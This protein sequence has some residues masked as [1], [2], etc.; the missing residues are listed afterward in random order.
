MTRN[1]FLE[2]CIELL[3]DFTEAWFNEFEP[4]EPADM[5]DQDITPM[6]ERFC[7]L[8]LDQ[9]SELGGEVS[10]L[11]KNRQ[12]ITS[13]FE[14]FFISTYSDENTGMA[15]H[16]AAPEYAERL[17]QLAYDMCFHDNER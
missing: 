10:D 2:Y 6:A 3:T 14:D 13:V 16:Y 12:Q 15:V 8:V 9:I 1:E 11:G 5:E 17:V 4:H 7:G